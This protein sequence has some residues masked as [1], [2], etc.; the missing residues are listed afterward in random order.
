MKL[1]SV[2]ALKQELLTVPK[3][4]V[5]DVATTRS[6]RAFSA[7]QH[8]ADRAMTRIAL[9]VAPAKKNEYRLAIRQQQPGPLVTA[10]TEQIEARAKGE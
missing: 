10:L 2:R 5:D 8:T 9:G 4:L 7:R 3:S 1:A 6:F